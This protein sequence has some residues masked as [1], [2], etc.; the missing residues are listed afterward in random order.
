M[1]SSDKQAFRD[2]L[3]SS[4]NIVILS[5]AGISVASGIPAYRGSTADKDVWTANESGTRRFSTPQAFQEHPDWA[6]QFYHRWRILCLDAKPNMAHKSLVALALPSVYN[7]IAPMAPSPPLHIAQNVDGILPR[8]TDSLPPGVKFSSKEQLIEMHGSMFRTRC[9]SC[10][11]IRLAPE[12]VL[13]AALTTNRET[14]SGFDD[15]A[16]ERL[17]RCGGDDWNGSNRY[18]K[19]GGLLRPDVVW[20]GEVAPMMGEIARKL[21]WCDL[22]VVVGTSFAVYPPAGFATQVKSRGGK[23]AVFNLEP[24]SGDDLADFLFLGKC[25][26]TLPDVLNIQEDLSALWPLDV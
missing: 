13:S 21:N 19:C 4:K 7:R 26:D 20:F 11:H 5:G 8:L 3:A 1:A 6:W 14:K 15:I 22:L 12:P 25:E 2:V 16:T 17:P 18:G 10:S 24:S 23:V 9:T